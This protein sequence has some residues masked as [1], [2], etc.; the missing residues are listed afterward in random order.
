MII[1]IQLKYQS[2]YHGK[3]LFSSS[4]KKRIEPNK[5]TNFVQWG[6]HIVNN[7]INSPRNNETIFL[8][9]FTM[10]LVSKYVISMLTIAY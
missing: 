10:V 4:R 1:S 9:F 5:I 2:Y 7:D 3:N 8:C 6:N